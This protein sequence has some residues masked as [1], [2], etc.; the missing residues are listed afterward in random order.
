MQQQMH[1]VAH[2]NRPKKTRRSAKKK[3]WFKCFHTLPEF[4]NFEMLRKNQILFNIYLG[5]HNS[6]V[7]VEIKKIKH[8]KRSRF[9]KRVKLNLV[10]HRDD[11][12]YHI[13]AIYNIDNASMVIHPVPKFLFAN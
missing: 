8:L 12:I 11:K 9:G 6:P 5:H 2:C 7:A 1:R 3:Y 4:P 10:H 13:T